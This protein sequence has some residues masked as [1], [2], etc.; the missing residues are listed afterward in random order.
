M[1]KVNEDVHVGLVFKSISAVTADIIAAGGIDKERYNKDQKF[2]FRGIEDILRVVS[3]LLVKHRLVI[4]PRVVDKQFVER[5]GKEGKKAPVTFLTMAFD[6]V[7]LAD[8]S[9]VTVEAVGE[10]KDFGDKATNKAMSIAYKYAII[11]AFAIPTEVDEQEADDGGSTQTEDAVAA[12]NAQITELREL[13]KLAHVTE[14]LVCKAMGVD[15]I[16]KL[17]GQKF[18]SAKKRLEASILKNSGG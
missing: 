15:S 13:M 8:G 6:I 11:L 2:Y 3:P 14:A 7:S 9:Q 17:A 1:A 18:D 4:L 16:E 10:G 12:D 5:E